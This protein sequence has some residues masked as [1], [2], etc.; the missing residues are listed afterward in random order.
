MELSRLK[1]EL[2]KEEDNLE[3]I[4]TFEKYACNLT[5]LTN[6]LYIDELLYTLSG[7]LT[8]FQ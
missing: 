2:E 4:I 8:A 6:Q 3:P 5:E 7:L 1:E